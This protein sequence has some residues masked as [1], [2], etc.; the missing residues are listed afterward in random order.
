M[1]P[2]KGEKERLVELAARNADLVLSQDNEKDQ[3]GKNC[4]PLVRLNQI[5]AAGSA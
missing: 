2:K 3:N 4:A 1:V 5:G